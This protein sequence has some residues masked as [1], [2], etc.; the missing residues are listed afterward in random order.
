MYLNDPLHQRRTNPQD[1]VVTA[2]SR[3]TVDDRPLTDDEILLHCD[4]M[5]TS[6]LE[7]TPSRYPVPG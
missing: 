3:S 5:L 4:G 6:G 7:T 1:D 2:L